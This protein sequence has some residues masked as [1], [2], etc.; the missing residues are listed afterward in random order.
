[1]KLLL[2]STIREIGPDPLQ[3]LSMNYIPNGSFVSIGYIKDDEIKFGPTSKKYITPENDRQL[4]KWIEDLQP[5]KFRD[6]LMDFQNSER[7]QQALTGKV[8][9]APFD[10]KGGDCHVI[11]INRFIMN[12]RNGKSL[13]SWYKKR[14]DKEDQ[15]RAKYGF[16]GIDDEYAPD[17]WRRK[18][19]GTGIKRQLKATGRQGNRY[20]DELMDT[21]FYANVD[22]PNKLAIRLIENPAASQDPVWYFVDGEGNIEIL[23]N[24]LMGFLAF[25]YKGSR[26]KQVADA[27]ID[28]NEDEKAFLEELHN[29]PNWNKQE[30]T[31]LFDKILYFTGTSLDQY[32]NKEPFTWLNKQV[33]IKTFPYLTRKINDII[34]EFIKISASEIEN[35]NDKLRLELTES[36]MRN[37]RRIPQLFDVYTPS[38]YKRKLYEAEQRGYIRSNRLNE[39]YMDDEI[40]YEV[41]YYDYDGVY[42]TVT[43]M[44][45]SESDAR[46][47]AYN[48]YY[49]IDEIIS[50]EEI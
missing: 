30:R 42:Q 10:F 38:N 28:I 6:A 13:A 19:G 15:V 21:G 26:V 46:E 18:Y 33:I 17:D 3:F 49:D 34:T 43:I 16:G 11:K 40:E 44:A 47:K 32:G 48:D 8:K 39:D 12:W 23:N 22:D 50:I 20:K 31:Q 25:A 24:E 1:M 27:I 7:Y 45:Y 14:S 9:T 4:T 2:E 37:C 36:Q 41:S 29:I 5:S 35:M